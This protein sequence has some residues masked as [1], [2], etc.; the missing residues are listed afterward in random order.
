MDGEASY[1]ASALRAFYDAEMGERAT[2]PLGVERLRHVEAFAATARERG[3]RSVLEVGC[4]AGRDGRLLRDAGLSYVGID[5]STQAART[6]HGLGLPAVQGSATRLPFASESVDAAW[7]MSTLM[8]LPGDGFARAVDELRRVV[9]PGGLVELGVWGH[10][11]DGERTHPDGRYFRHR[12]DETLRQELARLGTLLA[13]ETWD[14]FEDGGH[15]QWA[16]VKSA[17]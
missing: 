17:S 14:W 6:C 1:V 3:C 11:A 9:R 4:G 16:R 5:L 8:H 15:Y 13:F 12:T 2:R 7:T 10:A